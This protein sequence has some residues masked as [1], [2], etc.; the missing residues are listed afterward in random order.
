MA[1]CRV[2]T[3][4]LRSGPSVVTPPWLVHGHLYEGEVDLFS[5]PYF[6]RRVILHDSGGA[7][8][9]SIL[10]RLLEKVSD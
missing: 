9:F 5:P 6:G 10:E 1:R 2:P 4:R 8:T 3:Y 7:N